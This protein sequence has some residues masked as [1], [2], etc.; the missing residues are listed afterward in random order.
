MKMHDAQRHLTEAGGL[1]ELA[2]H[3]SF[4]KESRSPWGVSGT[5]INNGTVAI[6]VRSP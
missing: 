2:S 5:V 1:G 6:G 4:G 3:H